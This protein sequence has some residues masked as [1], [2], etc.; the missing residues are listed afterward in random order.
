MRLQKSDNC[1]INPLKS[2]NLRKRYRSKMYFSVL[3][4]KQ[5][6]FKEVIKSF[7]KLAFIFIF[8]S[9]CN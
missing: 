3:K 4:I 6:C 7:K 5:S 8:I 2:I 1:H 9:I